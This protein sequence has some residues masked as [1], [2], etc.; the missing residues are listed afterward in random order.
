MESP[1]YLREYASGSEEDNLFFGNL[2]ADSAISDLDLSMQDAGHGMTDPWSTSASTAFE[3]PDPPFGHHNRYTTDPLAESSSDWEADMIDI[4]S[5]SLPARPNEIHQD[6]AERIDYLTRSIQKNAQYCIEASGKMLALAKENQ[7]LYHAAGFTLSTYVVRPCLKLGNT[8]SAHPAVNEGLQAL[9]DSETHLRRVL[10]NCTGRAGTISGNNM[11][12][13]RR[14]K[15][16]LVEQDALLQDSNQHM[17]RLMRERDSLK[18]QV[19]KQTLV[20]RVEGTKG[21]EYTKDESN[22]FEKEKQEQVIT[23][24]QIRELRVLV[25][26][27]ALHQVCRTALA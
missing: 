11:T 16:R 27:L 12:E 15:D 2:M 7:H 6:I 21:E 4:D 14:L 1:G 5:S 10:V 23:P 9:R 18:K 3:A 8:L 22:K 24:D 25:D 17:Q 13:I 20:Q 26:Q 19:A